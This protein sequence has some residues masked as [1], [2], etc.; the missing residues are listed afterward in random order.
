MTKVKICGITNF[1]DAQV[2]VEAGADLLGFIFYEPSP[3]YV[4]PETVKE[5][6]SRLKHRVSA[7]AGQRL[8][9]LDDLLPTTHSVTYVGVFVNTPLEMVKQILDFCQLDAAQL[10]GEEPPEAVAQLN[11]PAFR[12]LRPQSPEEAEALI[13]KYIQ[14]PDRPVVPSSRLPLFLLDA[15]HPTLY[16]GVGAVA[17]WAVAAGLSQRY[18]L[19]LAGGLTPT[20]VVEAIRAVNPWGV[21]VSSGVEAEKGRKDHEKVRAFVGAVRHITNKRRD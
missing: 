6:V 16:G 5:I 1:E 20:N 8:D 21:D 15:Y 9:G 12:V 2:A 19:L 4:A 14:S 11:S 7:P 13:Q 17:D 18:P 10:H 3:R